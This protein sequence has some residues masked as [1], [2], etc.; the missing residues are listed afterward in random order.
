MAIIRRFLCT[1][2]S[3]HPE[4]PFWVSSSGNGRKRAF[5][6]SGEAATPPFKQQPPL[7]SSTVCH[8]RLQPPP[9]GDLAPVRPGLWNSGHE[10]TV[11]CLERCAAV[12]PAPEDVDAC[13][14]VGSTSEAK[15]APCA[16]G[17]SPLTNLRGVGR[18]QRSF[19][20]LHAAGVWPKE[21]GRR[22]AKKL[23]LN[24]AP[25][26]KAPKPVL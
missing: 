19:S 20:T 5:I 12:L 6:G 14:N 17:A 15:V 26:K 1:G 7:P 25:T 4:E 21:T 22:S 24:H 23:E 18:N 3:R 13:K 10:G 16:P 11:E 9:L 2:N 8:L